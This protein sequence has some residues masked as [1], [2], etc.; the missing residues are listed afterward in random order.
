MRMRNTTSCLHLVYLCFVKENEDVIDMLAKRADTAIKTLESWAATPITPES[1]F[2]MSI[3]EEKIG[4]RKP[5]PTKKV[6]KIPNKMSP[7]DPR[8]KRWQMT[9]TKLQMPQ[10]N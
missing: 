10:P 4:K 1:L 3:T 7:S 2:E 9:Q 8:E 5:K 6:T